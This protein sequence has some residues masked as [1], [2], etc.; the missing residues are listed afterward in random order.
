MKTASGTLITMLA[1]SK[2][3]V[4]TETFTFTLVDGTVLTF[5]SG[6]LPNNVAIDPDD[7]EQAPVIT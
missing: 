2:Q 4:M 5:V 1:T 3:F 7:E 6:D